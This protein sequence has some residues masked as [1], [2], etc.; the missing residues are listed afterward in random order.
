MNNERPLIDFENA[1]RG[2]IEVGDFQIAIFDSV[3]SNPQ[4]TAAEI[5][6]LQQCRKEDLK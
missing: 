5:D 4:R 2:A 6:M 3:P 1:V